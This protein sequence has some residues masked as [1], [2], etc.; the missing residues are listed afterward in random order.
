MDRVR[1]A[2]RAA[3]GREWRRGAAS[4]FAI[5]VLLAAAAPGAEAAAPAP[6]FRRAVPADDGYVARVIVKYRAGSALSAAAARPQHAGRLALRLGLPM[7]DGRVLGAR[8]QA[9]RAEGVTTDALV[10]QLAGQPDVEWAVADRRRVIQAL[11]NDPYLPAGQTPPLPAA[12]QWYLRAP[13]ATT[14]A[15]IDAVG[16]WDL[17]IGSEA[18]TV[19]VLDTGVRFDH[20][21]LA[22]KLYRGYDFVSADSDGSFG[23]AGDGNARDADASD[24][25]DWTTDGECGSGIDGEPSSWHGTQVAGLVGAA[26]DNAVGVAG[27][28]YRTMVLPLRVLGKCGG[29][30][31]DII[32]AMRWAAG[33]SADPVRNDHPARVLNLSLGSPGS[34]GPAYQGAVDALTAAGVTVVAAAGNDVGQAVMAPA[35]C[36]GVLAVAGLRHLGTKVGLSNIGPEVALAAPAGNCVSASGPCQYALLTTTNK[37]ETTPSTN[38][39]TDATNAW[40]GTSFS[41]PLVA[42][43]VALMLARDATLTP[44]QVRSLLQR[45]ARPFPTT[46]AAPGVASCHAPDGSEQDECY[47]TSETCGAGMLDT[48]A[49]VTLPPVVAL[50]VSNP[51][52]AAGSELTLDASGATAFAGRSIASYRWSIVGDAGVA[53]LKGATDAPTVTVATHAAGSVEV[54]VTVTDTSGLESSAGTTVTVQAAPAGGA[55]DAPADSGGGWGGGA[56]SAGWLAAL[57]AAVL[58]LARLPEPPRT[59]KRAA[60]GAGAF[61]RAAPQGPKP[62]PS[63]GVRSAS[64]FCCNAASAL[65][66]RSSTRG[67]APGSAT[68]RAPRTPRSA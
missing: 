51:Q 30:D 6:K 8:T 24:P 17:T 44:A 12:G 54:Q 27:V 32:A 19:A 62:A 47:C 13:D 33:L 68:T 59:L 41:A 21:D 11:P 2:C 10:Q 16:A 25:G 28:G 38:G 64:S 39:Y 34:C 3:G 35:N 23:T 65:A 26:T 53:E 15:A 50:R 14:P 43:T 58:V 31:S 22:A 7:R 60:A 57:V 20:P 1:A 36:S 5:A 42:G 4:L 55:T 63:G 46:G 18:Q 9:L 48:A 45:T 52:P 56:M 37:G 49:A 40:V 66:M 67:G 61:Q 29:Y